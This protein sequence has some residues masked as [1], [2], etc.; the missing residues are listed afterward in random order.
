MLTYTVNL[1]EAYT[2]YDAIEAF[3]KAK[4]EAGVTT[5][6]Y[7]MP[8]FTFTVEEKAEKKPWY[9]KLWSWITRKK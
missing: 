9:K 6:E 7:T 2:V 4:K 1:A 3:N 5:E 8:V